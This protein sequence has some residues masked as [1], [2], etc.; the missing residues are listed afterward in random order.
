[1]ST[2]AKHMKRSHRSSARARAAFGKMEKRAYIWTS[3]S[4]FG[5]PLA[6]KLTLFHRKILESQKPVQAELE[7]ENAG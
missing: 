5:K 3:D 2:A 1:M 4:E 7:V 6:A